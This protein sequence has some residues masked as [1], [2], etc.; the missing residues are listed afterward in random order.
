LYQHLITIHSIFRWLVIASLVV[1]IIVSAK[2]YFQHQFFSKKDD[3]IRHWIATIAHVQ[4]IIGVLLYIKSPTI[5]YFW[6]NF[7]EAIKYADTVFFGLVHIGLMLLSVV[8]VTIGSALAKRKLADTQRYKTMLVW[9]SFS[10][11]IIL[12]AIPWP[13]S[14]LA[15]RPYL[16]TF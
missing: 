13:F 12:I 3:A 2:G 11:F 9:F 4:L 7:N 5:K 8:L 1:A 10:L 6:K 16:R 14:P 15:S